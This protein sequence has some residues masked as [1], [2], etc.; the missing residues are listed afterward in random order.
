VLKNNGIDG[1]TLKKVR[2]YMDN[3]IAGMV[4]NAVGI[5]LA[6]VKNDIDSLMSDTPAGGQSSYQCPPS[7]AVTPGGGDLMDNFRAGSRQLRRK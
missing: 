1:G 7:C 2:A 3:P 6:R 4:A 5:N